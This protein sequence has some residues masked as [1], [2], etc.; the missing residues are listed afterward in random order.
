MDDSENTTLKT[1]KYST[2]IEGVWQSKSVYLGFPF[3][4]KLSKAHMGIL[5][6]YT[7]S[8]NSIKT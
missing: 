1:H 2:I 8:T 4:R 3:T 7:E 5:Y 6:A